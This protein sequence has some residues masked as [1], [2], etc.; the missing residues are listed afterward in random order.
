MA[1]SEKKSTKTGYSKYVKNALTITP[2]VTAIH[3]PT[4]SDGSISNTSGGNSSKGNKS[5][6]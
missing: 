5:K 3:K 1:N 2:L 4:I 6:K